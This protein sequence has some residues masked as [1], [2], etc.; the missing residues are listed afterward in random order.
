[1][2]TNDSSVHLAAYGALVCADV[3]EKIIL[4]R[5]LWDHWQNH[6][7]S[8]NEDETVQ[9]VEVP[10]RPERPELV[11]PR[12]LAQRK[13]T[14]ATG[15]AALIHAVTHIEF[16]AINLALDAVYRFRKL[17]YDYYSD[18]LQVAVEEA[19]HFSLLSDRLQELG[20]TYG[21]FPAHNGLW[22]MAVKTD[23]DLLHRMAMVPRVF[24]ARGLDVTPG[25]MQK[26]ESIGDQ[27]TVTILQIILRDEIGHVRIGDRWYRWACEQQQLEPEA[28]FRE[29]LQDY[30]P[31]QV[32]GPFYEPARLEA[33]FSQEELDQLR[34][35]G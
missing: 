14:S 12:K 21:D 2:Q 30:L 34:S 23:H 6:R 3:D 16:N 19:Y 32:R 24:E 5:T 29:L 8:V 10:G 31:G 20:Y 33:G 1:M 27:E 11:A 26:F 17:P 22:E 35:A 7:L 28:T 25:M 9:T 4:V 13:L 18:W 15:Q